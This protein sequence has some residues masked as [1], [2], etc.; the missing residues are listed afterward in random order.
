MGWLIAKEPYKLDFERADDA[1]PDLGSK[2]VRNFLLAEGT[3][4]FKTKGLKPLVEAR[5]FSF[6]E[7]KGEDA[8]SLEEGSLFEEDME[9]G[10]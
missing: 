1:E 3:Y 10:R 4:Y 7:T 8:A 2:G 9:L 6:N 5:A